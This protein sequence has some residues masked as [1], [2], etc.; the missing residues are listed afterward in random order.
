MSNIMQHVFA[1]IVAVVVSTTLIGSI[2]V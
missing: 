1:S 2:L